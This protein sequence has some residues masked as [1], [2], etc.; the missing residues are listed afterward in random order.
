MDTT[1]QSESK[2]LDNEINTMINEAQVSYAKYSRRVEELSYELQNNKD[3]QTDRSENNSYQIAK[4]ER[5]FAAAMAA[6]EQQRIASMR[7]GLTDYVPT[8]LITLGTT[9]ELT[10]INVNGKAP[11]FKP[12]RFIVKLVPHDTSQSL[13]G[14]VAVDSIVGD[15]I[16][17]RQP[18]EVVE[19]NAPMGLITYK[20]ERIY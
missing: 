14:L 3:L 11:N 12:N 2:R 15:A 10:I 18:G 17:N 5:D 4:D 19:I 9:V 6:K 20:I 7:E 8:G 1:L 13:H 16:L